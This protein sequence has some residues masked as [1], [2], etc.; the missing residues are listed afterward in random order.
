MSGAESLRLERED[1][2]ARTAAQ[3][4]FDRPVVLEAGAG[5]GKTTALVGRIVAWALGR[6][7][8]RAEREEAEA[9]ASAGRCDPPEAERVAARVL[10]GT[11]AITFTDAAAAEMATRVGTALRELAD[12]R[13]PLG[14]LEE[15]LCSEPDA[16]LQRARALLAAL[17]HLRVSTIHAFCRRLLAAYPIEARVHPVFRVDPDER[18]S[19]AVAR[20]VVEARYREAMAG[21]G[22]PD[23]LRLAASGIGPDAIVAAILALAREG[24]PAAAL[25]GG[26]GW[27]RE[28]GELLAELGAAAGDLAALLGE[29]LGGSRKLAKAAEVADSCLRLAGRIAAGQCS[30]ADA[31]E[32]VKTRLDDSVLDRLSDWRRGKLNKSESEAFGP[33]ADRLA[34]LAGVV[35]ETATFVRCLDEAV[36]AAASRVV[37]AWLEETRA[38]LRREGVAGFGDLLRICRELL[39]SE[40]AVACRERRSIHQLLVDEFQDTDAVQCEILA[41]LGLGGQPGERPGIFLVGDPKQSIYGWRQADLAAY[42]AFV[43]RVLGEGGELHRLSVNFRSVAAVLEEVERAMRPVM[44]PEP[45][46]QPAFEPL[47]VGPRLR[48]DPGFL[49]GERG[50]VE[51][52]VTPAR[53]AQGDEDVGEIEPRAVAADI[54]DLHDRH[55]VA[56]GEF[57]ILMRSTG[58]LDAYL[59][60]LR[61]AAVPHVVE[62]DRSYYLRREVIDASALIR[63]V[64]DPLDHL[65]LITWMRS[66]T[67]GV[68]D[69]ALLP[70]WRNGFPELVS[71]LSN[72]D[73]ASHARISAAIA[74]AAA[75]TPAVPGLDRV[76]GWEASLAAAVETLGQLRASFARD[77][78]AVFVE[79]LRTASLIEATEAAR[80]LG[81]YRLA[82]LDRLFR[83]LLDEVDRQ[84]ADP[85]AILAALRRAVSERRDEEEGRLR[86]QVTEAVRVMTIHRAKGLDFGH[87]YLVNADREMPNERMPETG[88]AMTAGSWQTVLF[89]VPSPGWRHVTARRRRVAE[90]EL[91]RTLYVALTRAK[92]RVVVAG[93]WDRAVRE[94]AGPSHLALLSR[95]EGGVPGLESLAAGCREHGARWVNLTAERAQPGETT[96]A[97]EAAA[98]PDRVAVEA[99]ERALRAAAESSR[100]RAARSYT[101]AASTEAHRRVRE[102]LA[103]SVGSAEAAVR[104]PSAAR[105]MESATLAGTAV[106]SLL[107]RLDLGGDVMAQI[108]TWPGALGDLLRER[109]EARRRADELVARLLGSILPG[110]LSALAGSVLARELPII[111]PP[112]G[113]EG[114]VGAVIGAVDLL[115]RDAATGEV[116]VADYKTDRVGGEALA[117]RVEAYRPQ[118]ETYAG[119]IGQALGLDALPATELWFLHAGVVRRL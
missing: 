75:S 95:R 27:R 17:D 10:D 44:R 118:L 18:L 62:R 46:V 66:A 112:A 60:A 67:V 53:E 69:A 6:G 38:R 39:T 117:A 93:R 14:V 37:G 29:R 47:I 107:E 76:R 65:A 11:V 30:L 21:S 56:W 31:H 88:A 110:R 54:R 71:E 81:R 61:E 26:D 87:V 13:L 52:W 119:A 96:E 36:H 2:L 5:T 16:R 42:Q 74:G 48:G 20:A 83:S 82:N 25:R 94:G 80:V 91:V 19:E 97:I 64:V 100:L 9:R 114:P 43:D 33:I 92:R 50:P 73:E 23:V 49:A 15:G 113:E 7:W 24:I 102:E 28:T 22:D 45:G 101:G 78:A 103:E 12:G 70:L 86:E 34:E 55:G 35:R 68:P 84:G 41:V 115:Y 116:V 3:T 98:L 4:V 79:R 8:E 85:E 90:A 89:G 99:D 111:V 58:E 77:P 40:P 32:A 51:Y 108:R 106:H 104:T 105:A 57:A 59:H 72:G 1:R 63:A 109:P